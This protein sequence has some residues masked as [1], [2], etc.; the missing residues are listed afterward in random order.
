MKGFA[1][2]QSSQGGFAAVINSG[3]NTGWGK[4]NNNS[5]DNNKPRFGSFASFNKPQT[6]QGIQQAATEKE[7]GSSKQ[8][9]SNFG[10]FS[11]KN[12]GTGGKKFGENFKA[13]DLLKNSPNKKKQMSQQTQQQGESGEGGGG[14]GGGS[15]DET[16]LEGEGEQ[17]GDGDGG[18]GDGME[19]NCGEYNLKPIVQLKEQDVPTGHENETLIVN[20]YVE[21]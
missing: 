20:W 12:F 7:E 4:Q 5:K 10:N 19:D 9:Q 21:L 18:G 8:Q 6:Q 11:F 13:S 2:F 14:G 1:N 17:D 16:R 15:D 3:N